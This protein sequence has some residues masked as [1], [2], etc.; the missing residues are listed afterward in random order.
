MKIGQPPVAL[1]SSSRQVMYV[2]YITYCENKL[3]HLMKG[4]HS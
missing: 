3:N 1:S 4:Y 2:E